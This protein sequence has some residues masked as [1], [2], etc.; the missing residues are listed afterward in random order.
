MGVAS[1]SAKVKTVDWG[2]FS[3]VSEAIPYRLIYRSW[4]WDKVGKNHFGFTMPGPILGM[5]LDPA[6]TEGVVQKFLNGANG[7]PKKEIRQIQ[8]RFNKKWDDQ[9]KAKEVRD[10]W[11]EDYQHGLTIAKSIQIDES[12]LWELC[13]FAEYGRESAKGREYGPLNGMYRGLI[14]D[15]FDASVNLQLVQKVKTKWIDDEPSNQMEPMGF[16]QAGNIVQ[17]SLEHRYDPEPATIADRFKCVIVNCRQNTEIW[18]QEFTNLSF[19]ELGQLVYP[20]S[21][22]GDW[23]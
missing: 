10:Q 14:Q 22:E 19:G 1:M 11:I 12:E 3:P 4:G 20:N 9:D 17:V 18:G 16:K 15:A 13:R 8:Y 23:Q 2:N 5:Y 21:N 7:T 6:G